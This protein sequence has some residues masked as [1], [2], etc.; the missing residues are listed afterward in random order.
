M[1]RIMETESDVR[2]VKLA[3]NYGKEEFSRIARAMEGMKV[4]FGKV[5]DKFGDNMEKLEKKLEGFQKRI[6]A[7]YITAS[8][9]I[10]A[11][12]A[13]QIID[14]IKTTKGG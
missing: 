6:I 8:G 14:I 12:L 13:N 2:E 7:L 4:D 1:E 10:I 11:F 9:A 3:L 5:L